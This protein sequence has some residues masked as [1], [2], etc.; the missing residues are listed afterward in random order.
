[1]TIAQRIREIGMLRTMG[2]GRAQVTRS[3]LVESLMLGA[4]GT[5]LG[6]LLGLVLTRMLVAMVEAF[7]VPFSEV[8]YPGTA[9]V[10]A[11]VIGLAA[12][13]AAAWQPARRA[14]RASPMEAVNEETAAERPVLGRRLAF[15]VP[16][17][18][19][20]LGGAYVLV[21]S[22]DGSAPIVAIG[23][24]GIFALFTGAILVAPVFI[25]TI[26]GALSPLVKLGGRLEGRIAVDNVVANVKR[27][28]ATA[29][30]LM[31]G[32]AMVAT[33]G[34]VAS[35]S[36]ATIKK[37][38]DA[39]FKSDFNVQPIGGDQG[40]G[41]QPTI[42][43]AV[44]RKVAA[45]DGV[46]VVSPERTLYVNKGF[47]DTDNWIVAINPAT[48]AE[49]R[50]PG[51][52]GASTQEALDG[53]ADGGVAI[54]QTYA[55][56]RGIAV[57]DTVSVDGLHGERK[58]KVVALDTT[59]VNA[60][61]GLLYSLDT[62]EDLYGLNQ[63][64]S[65]GIKLA[66][67][68]NV[69]RTRSAIEDALAP[70]PQIEL[71][72]TAELKADIERQQ[73][74][75]LSFFYALMFVAILIGLFGV[76]NTMFISVIERTREVGVLRAIGARRRQVRKIVRRE[77]II[78]AVSGTIMGLVVGLVLGGVFYYGFFR[79][80]DNAVYSPPIDL[81]ILSAILSVVFGVVAAGLPARRAAKTNVVEAVSY[82]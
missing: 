62:A 27:S 36:L 18:L 9:F 50:S 53:L 59:A 13:L 69:E 22:T 60:T 14:G 72:S 45:I 7:G 73:S 32:I 57:G 20:G 75:G 78:L 35:S 26:A 47:D 71:K 5:V 39:T 11:I 55:K 74:Q 40:G 15:G 12:T 34:T 81:I 23:I 48:T 79:N 67:G 33:F 82:E 28:A 41:P 10:L 17:M 52:V 37:Q 6:I 24:A 51:F 65:F 61:V 4:I 38:L 21:A 30:I 56:P 58:L 16:M 1:M 19:L 68:A 25:P 31:I 77:S 76:M 42:S 46:S 8:T 3:I 43:P 64:S 2:A 49:V 70:Y 66:K 29:A 54:S 80:L 44:A 63:D